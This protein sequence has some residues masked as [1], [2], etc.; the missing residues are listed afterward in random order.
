MS[1]TPHTEADKKRMLE[2]IGLHSIEDL[3][4]H[5]PQNLHSTAKINLPYCARQKRRGQ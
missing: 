1:Y 3:F 4:R 2:A 5:I